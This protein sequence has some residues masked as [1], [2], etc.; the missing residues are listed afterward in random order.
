MSYCLIIVIIFQNFSKLGVLHTEVIVSQRHCITS[1]K[2]A[3]LLHCTRYT[4][5]RSE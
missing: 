4:I 2:K 1:T 3:I 5:T